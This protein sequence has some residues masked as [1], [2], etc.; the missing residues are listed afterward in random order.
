MT[1]NNVTRQ[2][3]VIIGRFQINEIHAG[4]IALLKYVERLHP[5]TLILLGCRHSP[6]DCR[7][8][9]EFTPRAQMIRSVC[10]NVTILAVWDCESDKEWS[11]NV[12]NII[13][14]LF[15]NRKA[16]LYGGRNSFIDHYTG[17]FSTANLDFYQPATGS[18]V[19]E[20]ISAFPEDNASFRAGI[21]YGLTNLQ[22]RIFSTVD[23]AV[24]RRTST[25]RW[26][27]RSEI[28]LGR[29]SLGHKWRLPGGFIDLTD[30]STEDA[31][32]RE[33]FEET[34]LNALSL[35]YITSMKID[36]W[37]SRGAQDVGHMT[38]LFVVSSFENEPSGGDDLPEVKWFPLSTA[39][40]VEVTSE[41][42]P[43]FNK[44]LNTQIANLCRK[45]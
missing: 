33:L 39:T 17:S 3:G 35:T 32:R 44:L 42:K 37:R 10:P 43:L 1:G 27:F 21:I 19:R 23:I 14:G 29:K 20:K 11:L 38:M 2:V 25:N 24:L 5:S 7:N 6:P 12:D 45:N 4:H 36:D 41:H 30:Q 40:L 16:I 13:R 31:A 15:P 8:P 34:N 9:L 22:P 18:L 28:L 26:I